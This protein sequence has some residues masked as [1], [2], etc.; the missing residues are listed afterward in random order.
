VRTEAALHERIFARA[1]LSPCLSALR[2]MQLIHLLPVLVL[3]LVQVQAATLTSQMKLIEEKMTRRMRLT[4]PES[5]T[6]KN[7]E[8][9]IMGMAQK[10]MSTEQKAVGDAS[11]SNL[12]SFLKEISDLL[13]HTMKANILLRQNQTQQDMDEAWA[14]L[15]SCTHPNDTDFSEGLTTLSSKHKACRAEEDEIWT[16]YDSACIVA[17]QIWENEKKAIC[18]AYEAAKVFPN[19]A[20]AC[21]MSA[22]THLPTIGN[23]LLD[24]EKF[25]EETYDA[26]LDKKIKCDNA[27]A[28]PFKN[29]LLCQE[30]ICTYYDKK[31]AC[32]VKQAALE[33]D[34]CTHHKEY[35]CLKYTECYG[36]KVDVYSSVVTLAEESEST[37]KAEWRAVLRIECLVAALLLEDNELAPAI[38]TCKA[39]SYS[40][41][42]VELVYHGAAPATRACQEVYLQP[43]TAVFSNEWYNGVP[44]DAPALTC[45]SSCCMSAAF[46]S[47]YPDGVACPYAG[48]TTTTV[49]TTTTTTTTTAA[50]AAMGMMFG[51]PMFSGMTAFP[52]FPR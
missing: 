13:E 50:P 19:P 52:S 36:E 1:P 31:I 46:S 33:D 17:K 3:P 30:K 28:T 44:D 14:N 8:S 2:T 12:T 26:L 49:P 16:D 22:G 11:A 41:V 24:M 21:E 48:P 10:R 15:S 51:P 29:E 18:D 45:A 23:Y 39:K 6:L 4:A 32:D 34:A 35:T 40:T 27:T 47:T 20:T 7:I 38:D 43:G 5:N 42:P 25:F 37:A 9:S